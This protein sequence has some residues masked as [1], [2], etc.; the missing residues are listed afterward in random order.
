MSLV[1]ARCEQFLYPASQ[2]TIITSVMSK[3]LSMKA[4]KLNFFRCYLQVA[5][6]SAQ[7]AANEAQRLRGDLDAL[8]QQLQTSGQTT[9]DTEVGT[10]CHPFLH[11]G[12]SSGTLQPAAGPEG[13]S[14]ST[15]FSSYL[16]DIWH[17]STEYALLRSGP[18]CNLS[19]SHCSLGCI[20]CWFCFDHDHQSASDYTASAQPW[21]TFASFHGQRI[22][23]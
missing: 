14:K 18:L 21:G 22:C 15:T 4:C 7:Q 1:L 3:D 2:F 5:L 19:V 17:S 23:I 8:Q 6:T 10:V 9:S 13:C 12:S 16:L 20:L 11:V